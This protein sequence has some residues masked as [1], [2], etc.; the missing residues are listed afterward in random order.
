M[1]SEYISDICITKQRDMKTTKEILSENRES[2]ISSIKWTFKVFKKEEIKVK[3]IEFLNWAEN[4]ESDIQRADAAKNTKTLLKS[5]IMNMAYEQNRPIREAKE[6]A[7]KA[8]NLKTYGTER[9]KL[10]D[11]MGAIANR[12]EENGNVWHPIYKAWVKDQGHNP[13]MQKNPIFA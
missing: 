5:F 3:M 4:H 7:E 1:V 2:I 11:V 10:R 12:E 9:P 8:Y 13:S 6:K